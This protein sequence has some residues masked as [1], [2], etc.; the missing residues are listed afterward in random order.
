MTDGPDP[1][2]ELDQ[3]LRRANPVD[4]VRLRAPQDSPRA[5]FLFEQIT[6]V[7]YLEPSTPMR[8]PRSWL[9]RM[10]GYIAGLV[11]L[12]GVGGGLSYAL[13]SGQPTEQVTAACYAADSLTANRTVVAITGLGA[14]LDCAGAWKAG[15]IPERV[16]RAAPP[17][18][19][20]LLP[21][22]TAGVFPDSGGRARACG[23]LGLE[24][25][26][27]PPASNAPPTSTAP[28]NTGT[29]TSSPTTSSPTSS[30]PTTSTA[31]PSTAPVPPFVAANET[32]VSDLARSCLG[33]AQA[34]TLVRHVLDGAGLA[35]WTV[36]V[37]APFTSARPCASPS[38][39]QTTDTF[40]IVPIPP[41]TPQPGDQ[42]GG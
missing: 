31:P 36:Q 15:D 29:S 20:C 30:S 42:T 26:S 41:L 28:A 32:I 6:G 34:E 27:P 16:P 13:S 19:A 1:N 33:E 4:E 12:A 8:S 18:Q 22:G 37:A 39:D 3:L 2:F 40:Y 21:T 14:V 10:R 38:Y 23:R 5:R 7:A 24:P 25:V 35:N 11:A 9:R 17:L